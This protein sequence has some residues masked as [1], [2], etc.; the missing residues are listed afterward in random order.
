M[1]IDEYQTIVQDLKRKKL[2]AEVKL[3]VLA[4]LDKKGEKI[5][6]IKLKGVFD[7]TDFLV[8]CQG[9]S[10]RQNKALADAVDDTLRRKCRLHPFGVEGEA[11]GEWI[12]LDYVNFV[13]HIFEPRAREKYALEKM[14]MDAKQYRFSPDR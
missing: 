13:V 12:L 5:S 14:W 6:V 1:K 4:L 11:Y 7:L 10:G 2:P 8:I 3:A 9:N